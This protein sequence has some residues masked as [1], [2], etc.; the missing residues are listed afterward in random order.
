MF[1][2]GATTSGNLAELQ[3]FLHG[4][5]GGIAG[6]IGCSRGEDGWAPAPWRPLMST[7]DPSALSPPGT[8]NMGAKKQHRRV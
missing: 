8:P 3:K 5:G 2:L 6:L 4:D 1:G 7:I